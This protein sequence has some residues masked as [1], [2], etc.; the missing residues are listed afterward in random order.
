MKNVG[1][2]TALASIITL[3]PFGQ[4]YGRAFPEQ[5]RFFAV[6][7]DNDV[8][9]DIAGEA[10]GEDRN[11]TM[12]LGFV[13]GPE[14]QT[15]GWLYSAHDYLAKAIEV[16]PYSPK[17]SSNKGPKFTRYKVSGTAFTPEDLTRYDIVYGDRPYSFLLNYGIQQTT[18]FATSD[19]SDVDY[20]ERTELSIGIWGLDIGEEVQTF[21]HKNISDSP[22]PNGWSNQISDGGEPSFLLGRTQKWKKY[23]GSF[24][25]N[26]LIDVTT[27]VNTSIG[28]QTHVQA[29]IDVRIGNTGISEF[30]EHDFVALGSQVEVVESKPRYQTGMY[31]YLGYRLSGNIYNVGLQGQFRDNEY[32]ISA[33]D[34]ERIT[35]TYGFGIVARPFQRMGFSFGFTWRTPEFES[36]LY[37]RTHGYGSLNVF[38]N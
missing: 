5:E 23:E 2:Y 35:H 3:I 34:I 36:G 31:F 13:W 27:S 25:N 24:S 9:L 12:G 28:Y 16:G 10:F 7:F 26:I 38:W 8:L 20:S 22:I 11:Y 14:N 15:D 21:I 1:T 18:V 32:E 4:A 17:N 19:G 30:Y 29:G 33:G 6:Y 37:E